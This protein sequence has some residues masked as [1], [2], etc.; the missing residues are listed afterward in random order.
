[1][2]PEELLDQLRDVLAEIGVEPVNVLCPLAFGQIA[3]RPRQVD[4]E[5]RVDLLLRGA[6]NA[7]FDAGESPPRASKGPWEMLQASGPL[8]DHVETDP[9]TAALRVLCEP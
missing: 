6:H 8:D 9:Q 1:M 4:V 2:P 5:T 7:Q 3:L